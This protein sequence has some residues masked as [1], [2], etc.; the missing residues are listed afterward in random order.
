MNRVL[1]VILLI[2]ML[3]FGAAITLADEDAATPKEHGLVIMSGT[4]GGG[5]WNAA[6]RFQS[7]A[8]QEKHMVVA[9][10]ASSG[11]LE[12][13]EQLLN[14]DS[15][16]NLTF[17]QA[18][19]AQLYLNKHPEDLTKVDL[20]ENIGQECV[21]IVTG[22]DSKIQTDKDMET[23]SRL[24][25]GI[26][27]KQSGMAATFDYMTSQIPELNNV[28]VEYGDT[29]AAMDDL[30]SKDAQMDAIMM[31]HRPRE[32]SAEV[33]NAL[34]HP[35]RFRFV[36]LSDDRFTLPQLN[37]RPIYRTMKLALPGAKSPVKT[38]CVSGLLLIN[39]HK[40]SVAQRNEL[41]DLVAY[42]WM[43]IYAT[44]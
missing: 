25:L 36:E 8:M 24:R 1:P 34:A 33:D 11:S 10:L 40:L 39:K 21:F 2:G 12:N 29:V 16:V 44:Q 9:N 43:Q 19:A 42:H 30:N 26:A 15:P 13:I 6:A 5:Y 38:I 22:I 7:V 32:H 3:G 17:V 37:G 31:V 18:D 35:D 41:S 27:S 14:A 28:K 20:L 4:E 23:A